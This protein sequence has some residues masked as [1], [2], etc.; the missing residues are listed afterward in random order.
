VLP[1]AWKN[2][3][4]VIPGRAAAGEQEV[5]RSEAAV[6]AGQ[7]PV[8]FVDPTTGDKYIRVAVKD[9][10]DRICSYPW[11]NDGFKCAVV[12]TVTA[13]SEAIMREVSGYGLSQD[14]G[15][16]RHH[17]PV[18]AGQSALPNQ[19]DYALVQNTINADISLLGQQP[20]HTFFAFHTDVH[21][22]LRHLG[23]A[24]I[25]QAD[26]PRLPGKF[27]AVFIPQVRLMM[28]GRQEFV[29]RT[30]SFTMDAAAGGYKMIAGV[31]TTL[32]DVFKGPEI[33]VGDEDGGFI[34]LK[35]FWPEVL[36]LVQVNQ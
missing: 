2:I 31:K 3:T 18:G 35:T 13:G 5:K 9:D 32:K 33:K 6:K 14:Y 17:V 12:D 23:P 20:L 11:A 8:V 16:K 28:N 36:K 27:D 15:Q 4:V 10:L 22:K 25:G 19:P 29:V 1:E 34:G 24:T 26:I 7:Q 30:K 21:D